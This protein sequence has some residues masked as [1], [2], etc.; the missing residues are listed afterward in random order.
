MEAKNI[1]VKNLID[2]NI[3]DLE[4]FLHETISD[5]KKKIENI[6]RRKIVNKLIIKHKQ[7]RNQTS[8]NDEIQTVK[9]ARIKNGDVITI[10]KSDVYG[11]KIL[12]L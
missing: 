6:I 2:S 8:M 4:V 9:D 12:I 11:G 1:C 10:G 5:I 7:K 3:I